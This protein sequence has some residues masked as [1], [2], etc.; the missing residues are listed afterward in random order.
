MIAKLIATA[1]LGII[2]TQ[3]ALAG[4]PSASI[5]VGDQRLACEA[6][7]CLLAATRPQEC[8]ESINRYYRIKAKTVQKLATARADFLEL[9]PKSELFRGR[10]KAMLNVEWPKSPLSARGTRYRTAWGTA[11]DEA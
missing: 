5:L 2:T 9:C 7:M 3:T 8:N 10:E 11:G 1:V 4:T 6:T